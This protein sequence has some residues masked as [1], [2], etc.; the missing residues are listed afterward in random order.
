[1]KINLKSKKIKN[2]K[3]SLFIEYYKGHFIDKNGINKYNR[4]FEYLKM[5]PL[6]NPSTPDE[7]R[8]NKEIYE[9]AEK[10][11]SIRKSEFYQGKYKLKDNKKGK[12]LLFDFYKTLQEERYES[13]G[14]YGNW[15]AAFKHLKKYAPAHI[16]LKDINTDFVRGF[17]RY[18]DTKA[19]TKSKTPLSQ[20]SKY[21]YFNK[22]KAALREAYNENYIDTNVIKSVKGFEQAESQREY[23]TYSE[24]QALTQTGCKYPILKNA[25]IFSCLTGLRWSD[26]NKLT[27]AEVRDED[28]AS[29]IIFRQKK[30]DGLE[31][32]YISSQARDL[33]GKRTHKTVRVFKGLKYGAVYNTEILRWCMKAGI[34]KHITFHSARHTNAVLLL[35]NGADIYTVSK[36]LGHREIRTTEIYTKIID[37]KMKEAANMIPELDIGKQ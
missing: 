28:E 2:G 12:I 10:I 19:K 25:F 24:L 34:T 15:D 29:R 11:L 33:L 22:L 35:E 8:T 9:L 18:L 36:R 26:I 5:Y 21:T 30:T 31:Y 20:N 37:R 4:D 32:L 16:Q 14:N 17:K 6:E 13:K 1:M 27:W 23:L 7:K 3:L